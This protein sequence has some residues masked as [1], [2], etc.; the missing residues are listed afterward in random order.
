MS[1]W[2]QPAL[3]SAISNQR[4]GPDKARNQRADQSDLQFKALWHEHGGAG[5]CS[6]EH[7][8]SKHPRDVGQGKI[9]RNQEVLGVEDIKV[10]RRSGALLE[11]RG[12]P[13][14]DDKGEGGM[15]AAADLHAVPGGY[16]DNPPRAIHA[17][18]QASPVRVHA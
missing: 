7:R 8:K 12:R 17:G 9:R 18:R 1:R 6:R 14:F 16:V 4:D 3:Q 11:S 5:P 15:G 10:H 2:C 13:G